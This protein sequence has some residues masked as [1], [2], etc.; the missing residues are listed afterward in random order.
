MDDLGA[1]GIF[2]YLSSEFEHTDELIQAVVIHKTVVDLKDLMGSEKLTATLMDCGTKILFEEPVFPNFFLGH[3]DDIFDS[4]THPALKMTMKNN[5]QTKA[6]EILSSKVRGVRKFILNLPDGLK[7]KMG[8]MNAQNNRRILSGVMSSAQDVFSAAV[9]GAAQDFHNSTLVVT[10][11]IA[12]DSEQKIIRNVV[13][14]GNEV[15]TFFKRMS[16]APPSPWEWDHL[17]KSS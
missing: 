17:K 1:M 3:T 6:N 14:V 5:F 2:A 7:C 16:V 11:V 9:T 12:V 4:I 10:Y 8:Y 13:D 15:E